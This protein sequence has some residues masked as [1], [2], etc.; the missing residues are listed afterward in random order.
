MSP[1]S[2][3]SFHYFQGLPFLSVLI[4]LPIVSALLLSILPVSDKI[5]WRISLYVSIGEFLIAIRMLFNFF[6]EYGMFPLLEHRDWI[7]TFGISY[8]VGVDGITLW[9]I[10]LTAALTPIVL[11]TSWDS[12]RGQIR[13][14][15]VSMLFLEG[16]MMGAFMS[17]DLILFFLFWELMLVPMALL[18]GVWGGPRRIY[19]AIKFFLYTAFGSGLMLVSILALAYFH[20]AQTGLLTFDYF[21]LRDVVVPVHWA[22]LLFFG[23]ALAFAIKIPLF[24]F[25]TW[26]PDAHTEAP[27]GGSVILAGILLKFGVYGFFRFC[28][29]FFPDVAL[30][31]APAFAVLGVVGIIYGALVS[32]VQTD[33]KRLVAYSSVSHLGFCVL[34]L[35]AFTVEGM[36]GSLFVCLAH[37][38]STG[39]LFLLVGFIYDRRHTREISEYGGITQVMP[40]YSTAFVITALASAGLPGLCGFVG[41]FLSLAGTFI[42]GTLPHAKWLTAAAATAVILSA[43]YLLWMVQRVFFGELKNEKNRELTDLTFRERAAILPLLALAIWMGVYPEPILSRIRPSLESLQAYIKIKIHRIESERQFPAQPEPLQQ[44]VEPPGQAPE[45]RQ[46]V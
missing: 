15:I 33:I 42:S 8:L 24:P 3:E 45:S 31:F 21:I 9:L 37:G 1:V 46:T 5:V 32:M 28:I 35:F 12:V 29:P 41:E 23:F 7:P 44:P 39:A 20:Q 2:F 17:L 18:I 40:F 4:F 25:H 10:L 26:L 22:P 16:T 14:Y 19:A 11:L 6:P 30:K 43:V 36:A 34:G 38:V 13:A 27:T